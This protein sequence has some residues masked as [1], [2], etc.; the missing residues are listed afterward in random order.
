MKVC[1]C[2]RCGRIFEPTEQSNGEFYSRVIEVGEETFGITNTEAVIEMTLDICNSC[3]NSFL[4][5]KAMYQMEVES[6]GES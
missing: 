4:S 5:W 1:K 3:Y 2:D 6:N